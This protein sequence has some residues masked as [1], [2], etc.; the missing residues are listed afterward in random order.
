MPTASPTPHTPIIALLGG[1]CTG[2]S[3]L[4]KALHQKLQAQGI[5]SALALEFVTADIPINGLPSREH[6]VYEQFRFT[7]HQRRIEEQAQQGADIVVTD[8]PVMLGCVYTMLDRA[9]LRDRRQRAFIEEFND[10]FKWEASR[11]SSLFL[12]AREFAYED[13]GIRFHSEDEARR[14][15]QLVRMFLSEA[16]LPYE[17]LSGSVDARV[18]QIIQQLQATGVL[19]ATRVAA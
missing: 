8:C 17:T 2:K 9:R 4:A 7:Y 15:D 5:N 11:Y 12:L 10:I 6:V 3:T 16:E 13:N 14:V 18:D 1:P 19:P